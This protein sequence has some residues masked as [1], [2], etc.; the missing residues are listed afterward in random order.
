[1]VTNRIVPFKKA[2]GRFT[3]YC[4]FVLVALFSFMDTTHAATVMQKS[5]SQFGT[6]TVTNGILK[7]NLTGTVKYIRHA[8][9]GDP[10]MSYITAHKQMSAGGGTFKAFAYSC[11]GYYITRI[12]S[13][14]RGTKLVGVIKVYVKTGEVG[15]SSCE[16]IDDVTQ[17]PPPSTA[18]INVTHPVPHKV[19]TNNMVVP[20]S[21]P[22]AGVVGLAEDPPA[23]TTTVPKPPPTVEELIA[24]CKDNSGGNQFQYLAQNKDTGYY[25]CIDFEN[26]SGQAL[27]DL[28]YPWYCD[29]DQ[30]SFFVPVWGP[31]PWD[32]EPQPT[33]DSMARANY[34]DDV[35]SAEGDDNCALSFEALNFDGTVCNDCIYETGLEGD[36]RRWWEPIRAYAA[37]RG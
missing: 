30:R 12:Y 14:A 17:P 26:C 7:T 11:P 29:P 9:Y 10:Q 28:N 32:A 4:L 18:K 19:E 15:N 13:D 21:V 1:M 33:N 36:P 37:R 5:G 25:A 2:A 3:V 8:K 27:I 24:A 16:Q 6:P 34:Y 20:T 35:C 23:E 22:T 31:Y